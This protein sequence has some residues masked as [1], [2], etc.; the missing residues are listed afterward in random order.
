MDMFEVQFEK[1]AE[2]TKRKFAVLWPSTK[3]TPPTEANISTIFT[4]IYSEMYY[5]F[6]EVP[7]TMGRIDMV[8]VDRLEKEIVFCEF[9]SSKPNSVNEILSD[10]DRLDTLSIASM[11]Y[12]SKNTS[13]SEVWKVIF[14]WS[15]NESEVDKNKAILSETYPQTFQKDI[16][17]CEDATLFCLFSAWQRNHSK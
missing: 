14:Q 17:E 6:S 12:Y 10:I 9:K 4:E 7:I 11:P 3:S 13:P 1:F 5:C 2:I 16:I 15:E 8:L